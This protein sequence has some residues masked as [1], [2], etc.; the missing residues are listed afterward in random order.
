MM[1]NLTRIDS[2][3]ILDLILASNPSIIVNTVN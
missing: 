3:N 2:G 1:N